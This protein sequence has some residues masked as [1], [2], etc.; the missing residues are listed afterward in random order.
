MDVMLKG[1]YV[2]DGG[3]F[4]KKDITVSFDDSSFSSDVVDISGKYIFP[5]FADVHV[6]LREPGFSYKETVKTGTLAGAAGG[7]TALCSM[8]NLNPTPDS[9]PSLREQL[10]IIERDA[11]I[12]V[13]PYGT[14]TVGEKGETPSDLA[15][16]APCVC[17]FSDDGR[18]IQ[19]REMMAELM[20]R[21][22]SLGKMIAAHC[23]DNSLLEG[24]Y[25][26]KGKY[27]AE[28]GHKG[29]C[30]E[31]EWGPIA[32]DIEL[33]EAIGCPYHV[34]HISAKESVDIIRKAKARGVNITCETGPHYLTLCDDDLMEH[35][36]FKMNPPLRSAEDK[37]AL[38]EGLIDGT[39]DMIATDHAPHSD[40]EKGKGLEKSA[41]GVVGL[42]S[43][44]AV[45]YTDLVKTG[46]ISLERLIYL[47]SESPRS[48]FNID[49]DVGFTVFDLEAEY[50][51]DPSAFKSKG[52][53]TPFEGKTVYG[54]CLMT[55]YNGKVVY[56]EL[57]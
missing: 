12:A 36:R 27:A 52:R 42:E 1:G 2:Y 57:V 4:V 17:G 28:H 29:I 54:K 23:E 43:A 3:R 9:L 38:I 26:H 33:A 55:V 25:I 32:R 47:M 11:L 45:M 22:S 24:G 13:L 19:S 51:I 7:Y 14:L 37:A 53:A 10:N 40:E 21:V 20:K 49:T 5:G 48:R 41:M 56:N 15:G 34:C 6:H 30:S 39:I 16:M 35:G 46:V 50:K 44:F 31:S 8:P 18:G